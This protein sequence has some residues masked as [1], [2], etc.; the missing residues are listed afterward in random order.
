V[1]NSD[2][3]LRIEGIRKTFPGVVALEASTSICAGARC[4]YCS[5]R[6][7]RATVENGTLYA[8]VAQQPA[9]LGRIAVRNAVKAAEGEKVQ[10]SVMVP[11][12]VPVKVV[13]SE[14]VAE[15]SG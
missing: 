8:S 10:K 15:F 4:M 5:V 6:T 7:A 1:S 9:E 13:T 12:K 2:E 14:N 11:V 3:L